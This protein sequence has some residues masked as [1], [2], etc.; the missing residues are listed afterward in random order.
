MGN[1]LI[2]LPEGKIYDSVSQYLDFCIFAF[3]LNPQVNFLMNIRSYFF[4]NFLWILASMKI[5]FGQEGS[6]N[7]DKNLQ[8]VFGLILK[9]ES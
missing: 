8:H 1:V 7:Y 9:T 2:F 3:F 4:D 5:K 6:I